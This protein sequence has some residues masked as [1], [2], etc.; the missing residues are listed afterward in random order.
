MKVLILWN[1]GGAF[2]P[3]AQQL[4]ESEKDDVRVIKTGEFNG[5]GHTHIIGHKARLSPTPKQYYKDIINVIRKF[6]PDVIHVTGSIKSLI[7]ARLITPRTPVYFTYHGDEVRGRKSAHA[8]TKLADSVSVTTPDLR[9]YGVFIDRPIGK[10]FYDRGG[11]DDNAALFI[12]ND[13]W[14]E[15]TR[16]LAKKWCEDRGKDLTVLDVSKKENRIPYEEMPEFYS[17]FTFFLDFK[18]HV[19]DRFALSKAAI[20]A[21]ACGCTIVHDSDLFKFYLS[22]DLKIVTAQDY[23]G[24]YRD[25][26]RASI[27]IG[28]MRIPRILLGI[29]RW[30][31]GRLDWYRGEVKK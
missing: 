12:Y 22:D 1:M 7:V 26:K 25:M 28:L 24:L 30:G 5:Y 4:I 6:D 29:L 20:E 16:P 18:G 15:D 11:R 21:A 3:V 13:Y 27:W 31:T 14:F 2:T 9:D 17:K 10:H 19:K 8:E 23:I